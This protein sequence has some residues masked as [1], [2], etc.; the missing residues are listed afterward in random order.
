ATAR[1]FYG[2]ENLGV[3]RPSDLLAVAALKQFFPLSHDWS[4]L[5]GLSGAFG[6]NPT[7]RSNRSDVYGTDIY[8]KYR[9]VTRQSEQ[10]LSWQT[11]LLYRRRQVPDDL[12]QDVNLYTQLV[13]Q[14]TKRWA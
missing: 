6:P 12:L 11:E 8:L 7:G 14:L 2:A 4:L 10:M 1:S 3:D 5:W 9:P 13:F